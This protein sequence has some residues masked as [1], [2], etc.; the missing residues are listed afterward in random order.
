M[1]DCCECAAVV[2]VREFKEGKRMTIKS[3]SNPAPDISMVEVVRHFDEAATIWDEDPHRRERTQAIA[4]S[5]V[6]TVPL[7]SNWRVMEYGCGTAELSFLLASQVRE[8]VAADASAG[9]VDQIRRKLKPCPTIRIEPR[10]LDLVQE[11]APVERFDL[12]LVAMA[13]HHIPDVSELLTRLGSMLGDGGWLAIADLQA[14]DGSFHMPLTVPHNGFVPETMVQSINQAIG[15]NSCS[16]RIVH[17][18]PKNGRTYPVCL[19]TAQKG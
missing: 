5:I 9:M 15:T 11:P 4:R 18:F 7:K 14:E 19:W 8:V 6:A 1:G 13:L 17:E 12:I 16:W 10:L 2:H 3:N